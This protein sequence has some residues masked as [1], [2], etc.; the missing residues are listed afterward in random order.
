MAMNAR[1]ATFAKTN[2]AVKKRMK[3]VE[4]GFQ[5]LKAKWTMAK[6]QVAGNTSL[7]V[8]MFNNIKQGIQDVQYMSRIN[9]GIPPP[10][11]QQDPPRRRSN[12]NRSRE[13]TSAPQSSSPPL[14]PAPIL[15][16][17]PSPP[18]AALL[19]SPSPP[20]LAPL[21]P[22]PPPPL[23]APVLPAAPAPQTAL[24]LPGSTPTLLLPP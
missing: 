11:R 17:P 8:T 9:K 22:S 20:P 24:F 13:P 21:L 15:P 12:T 4:D 5:E 16:S 18:P 23:P 6:E 2:L 1:I 10:N 19:P 14:P 3:T 7:S